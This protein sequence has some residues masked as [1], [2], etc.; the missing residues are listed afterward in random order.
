MVTFELDFQQCPIA[1]AF[2]HIE[3]KWTINIIRDMLNGQ[4]KFSDFL[5]RN[6]ELSTRVLSLRLA[7]MEEDNL[8]YR[9]V[10]DT[11]PVTIEYGLTEKGRALTKVLYE[12]AMFSYHYHIKEVLPSEFWNIS[13]EEFS[14]KVKE[15]LRMI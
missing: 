14:N 5:N 4:Y 1:I 6:P 9:H 10:I 8:I 7:D 15:E 3:K 12:L 13:K 2:T 11:K